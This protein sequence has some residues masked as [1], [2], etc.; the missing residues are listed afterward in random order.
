MP[1][2]MKVPTTAQRLPLLNARAFHF[3]SLPL[4]GHTLSLSLS[5]S[6]HYYYS[7]WLLRKKKKQPFESFFPF[8]YLLSVS[9]YEKPTTSYGPAIKTMELIKLCFPGA[10]KFGSHV[11]ILCHSRRVRVGLSNKMAL[12]LENCDVGVEN[13]LGVVRPATEHYVKEAIQAL[14]AEKVIVVPTDTI[15]GFACDAWYAF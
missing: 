1:N 3:L 12:S 11:P 2:T 10:S 6:Q 15:Y 7:V 5:L 14:K 8:L 13:K 4:R 9:E